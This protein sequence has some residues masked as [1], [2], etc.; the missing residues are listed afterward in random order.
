MK[1]KII[2]LYL[3]YVQRRKALV[4]KFLSDTK[5]WIFIIIGSY[6]A[7]D[8]ATISLLP[9]FLS[10]ETAPRSAA[11]TFKARHNHQ[12]ESYRA[13][14][15]FNIFHQGPIPNSLSSLSEEK[16][17]NKPPQLSHLPLHLNGTIVYDDPLYS[18]ANITVKNQPS[19][20]SYRVDDTVDSLARVTRITSERVYFMN[21][22]SNQEEYIEVQNM[23]NLHFDFDGKKNQIRKSPPA[24]GPDKAN[25]GL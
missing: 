5:H 14:L 4:F 23:G 13:I 19:S 1:K 25:W 7:A 22:G 9:F 17:Q 8:L 10:A 16:P 20:E 21:L 12:G 11:D 24:W 18:V 15:D 2:S 3:K 6:C